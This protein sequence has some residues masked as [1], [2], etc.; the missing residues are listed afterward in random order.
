ME[1]PLRTS[2]RLALAGMEDERVTTKTEPETTGTA[3]V[4]PDS[5]TGA[6]HWVIGAPGAAMSGECKYCHV[7]RAFR[8]FADEEIGFNNSAKKHRGSTAV[9]DI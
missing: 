7:E 6:H 9:R 4:C 3:R 2:G 8:P 5:P 1:W